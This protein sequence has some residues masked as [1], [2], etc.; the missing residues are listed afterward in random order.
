MAAKVCHW[1]Y[2]ICTILFE[3]QA[4]FADISERTPTATK[5]RYFQETT[6]TFLYLIFEQAG[7]GIRITQKAL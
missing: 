1:L 7:Q 5:I 4:D 3:K 6:D 2:D